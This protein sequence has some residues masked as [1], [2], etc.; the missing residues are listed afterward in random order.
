MRFLTLAFLLA[1][2]GAAPAAAQDAR[3]VRCLLQVNGRTIFAGRCLFTRIG[4]DGSF[5]IKERGQR[6]HFAYLVRNGALT[7]GSW[8]GSERANHAD[9]PLGEMRRSGA[10]WQSVRQP[11]EARTIDWGKICAWK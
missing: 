1:L 8:N 7:D 9:N 3:Q 5:T 6:P 2:S 11:R 4:D 10:C